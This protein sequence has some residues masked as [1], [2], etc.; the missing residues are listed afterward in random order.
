M[1]ETPAQ[2]PRPS[3]G[4]G[5]L[6]PHPAD[7]RVHYARGA[8]RRADL[9]ANPLDL[10]EAWFQAAVDEGLPEPNAMTVATATPDG[11]PSARTVLCKG[12]N[13]ERGGI[14]FFTNYG[15]RKGR[16]L[17]AN[18]RAAATF[19]WFA[20][21][22]Q[23]CLRG[24]VERLPREASEAYFRSRPYGSQIGA[25]ASDQHSELPSRATLEERAEA[26]RAA[27][28]EGAVPLPDNWGG[29][30]L[31][32]DEWEFWQGRPSRLHDRFLYRRAPAGHW[33]LARLEP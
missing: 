23:A 17:A 33:I 29:Y 30:L 13:R 14:E 32:P 28:P 22:R 10:L 31:V 21:E 27:H 6:P 11:A 15:S 26:L 8:L 1:D 20:L 24:R 3:S 18:P 5:S 25:L 2:P 7:L 12:F 19:A 4:D 9:P 16:D